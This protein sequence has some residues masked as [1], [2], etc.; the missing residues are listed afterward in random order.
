MSFLRRIADSV[1]AA[2]GAAPAPTG[3]TLGGFLQRRRP[4]ALARAPE[5]ELPDE[6]LSA[7]DAPQAQLARAGAGE[8][9]E[10]WWP[11]AG[12]VPAAP[13]GETD[14]AP[15]IRRETDVAPPVAEP[16]GVAGNGR[17]PQVG[18][19]P[20][21]TQ[22]VSR[23]FYER[24]ESRYPYERADKSYSNPD[25]K[26]LSVQGALG[27]A[28]SESPPLRPA[29]AYPAPHA[30]SPAARGAPFAASIAPVP[31]RNAPLAPRG[32]APAAHFSR[33]AA[34]RAH[35]DAPA[36][37]LGTS[38]S[39]PGVGAGIFARGVGAGAF[40]P[41]SSADAGAPGEA[42]RT[43]VTPEI[44]WAPAAPPSASA[45]PYVEQAPPPPQPEPFFAEPGARVEPAPAAPPE[46]TVHIGSIEIIIEAPGEPR[47]A[48]A[49]AAAP[50]LS[51]RF[52]LRG[53]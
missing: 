29:A 28:P 51:S 4:L 40:A 9:N 27:T 30:A 53:L 21:G 2:P 47:A 14:G 32:A 8:L 7:Q 41:G 25:A 1:C 38:G 13:P 46:P 34:M 23:D 20:S 36:A 22:E 6:E 39:A 10:S 3:R 19:A 11:E 24:I 16:R 45:L 15:S 37:P 43:A 18:L 31:A 35:A 49:P 44:P 17:A 48:P 5:E 50:D 42:P 33:P 12:V 26:D 52:Y